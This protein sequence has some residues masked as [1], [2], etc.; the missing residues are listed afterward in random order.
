MRCPL[1]LEGDLWRDVVSAMQMSNI[2]TPLACISKE[3]EVSI[4]P[5]G[6]E[7][8]FGQSIIILVKTANIPTEKQVQEAFR[9]Y[10]ANELSA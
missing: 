5:Q 10:I 9:R 2:G 7:R 4:H 6:D 1:W 3:G 8:V